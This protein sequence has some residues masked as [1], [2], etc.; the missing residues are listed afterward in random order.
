[1]QVAPNYK[2]YY[3]SG[4]FWDSAVVCSTSVA[5]RVAQ[6]GAPYFKLT[7]AGSKSPEM[8]TV[9]SHD[10]LIAPLPARVEQLTPPR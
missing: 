5:R 9:A 4:E 8:W 7:E 1:M 6:I 10:A 3:V 2:Q